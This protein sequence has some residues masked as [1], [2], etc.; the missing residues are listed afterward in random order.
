MEQHSVKNSWGTPAYII[1]VFREAVGGYIDVDPA[2]NAK[3][4]E[5]IGASIWYGLG[6]PYGEDGLAEPWDGTVWLNPPYGK[7]LIQPFADK[8]CHEYNIGRTE[9]YAVLV[10]LDPSTQWFKTL[11]SVS[12]YIVLLDKR[13]AF[14]DPTMGSPVRGNSRSQVVLTDV[15]SKA[16]DRLGTV[17]EIHYR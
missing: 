7:G 6:S 3:A 8:L 16:W 10:N 1:E 12:A 11:L 5:I 9:G 17:C 14:V 15:A 13:V 2:S 4:Q